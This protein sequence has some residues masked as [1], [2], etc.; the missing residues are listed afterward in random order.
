[1]RPAAAPRSAAHARREKSGSVVARLDRR[2]ANSGGSWPRPSSPASGSRTRWPPAAAGRS[3]AGRGCAT[4]RVEVLAAYER[5]PLRP[6]A[7]ARRLHRDRAGGAS[8]RG[9][10]W[11]ACCTSRSAIRRRSGRRG[12]CRG[13]TRS[14]S[15]RS[16]SSSIPAS[17]R[18][19]PTCAG[20]SG[21]RRPE[22]AQLHVRACAAGDRTAAR[23]RAPEGAAEGDPALDP[24][25][26]PRVDPGPRRGARVR[27]RAL[28][29]HA[30]ERA[31]R[32]ARGDA[33]R[34]RGLLRLGGRRAGLR[35]LPDGGLSGVRRAHADRVVHERRADRRA[36]VRPARPPPGHAA[37]AAGRADVAR[38]RQPRRLP[39]RLSPRG[40]RRD[41][42]AL[43]RRPGVLHR[44]QP[45]AAA[46]GGRSRATR[47]SAST[48]PRRA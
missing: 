14:A 39:A 27:A 2:C 43:R 1:M 19:W 36:G 11:R 31:P 46:R 25:R 23:D 5:P 38:A 15:W 6:A 35:D 7:R 37:S 34:S 26:D 44:S 42:H 10:A 3:G 13:S 17:S 22:A 33:L 45:A 8:A 40:V 32:A 24:A 9:R 48:P 18:G 30:C 12:R 47:A 28:G 4:S 21:R 29:A 16:A 20:S 41:V